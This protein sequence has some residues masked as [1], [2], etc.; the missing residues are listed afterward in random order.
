MPDV[1]R[2]PDAHLGIGVGVGSAADW[3]ISAVSRVMGGEVVADLPREVGGIAD[4]GTDAEAN[5]QLADA[6][7]RRLT[8][9]FVQS[10]ASASST[11]GINA[12]STVCWMALARPPAPCGRRSDSASE[13]TRSAP[14][15]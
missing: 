2:R 4:L 1:G 6:D 12:C 13:P 10:R 7:D 14:I 8:V 3:T 15:V 9:G 5:P 11:A